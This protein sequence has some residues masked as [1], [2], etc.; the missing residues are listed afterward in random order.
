[1]TKKSFVNHGAQVATTSLAGLCWPGGTMTQSPLMLNPSA[2]ANPAVALAMLA[3]MRGTGGPN[4][5]L[6]SPSAAT[7]M[8]TALPDSASL[9]S[10][11]SGYYP[12]SGSAPSAS[13]SATAVVNSAYNPADILSGGAPATTSLFLPGGPVS[14]ATYAAAIAAVNASR[15]ATVIQ[16]PP[17][18]SQ[19]SISVARSG[20]DLVSSA[21]SRKREAPDDKDAQAMLVKT[22]KY[23]TA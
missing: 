9:A 4:A 17:S 21:S 5:T 6:Y 14:P 11:V 12:F 22:C 1:M 3:A 16:S 7:S 23:S 13:P 20:D 15:Q 8:Y 18:S 2:Q 19:P 10:L